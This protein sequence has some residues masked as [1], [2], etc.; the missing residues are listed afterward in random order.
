MLRRKVY[1]CLEN[2]LQWCC[3]LIGTKW[4]RK[5]NGWTLVKAEQEEGRSPFSCPLERL[6]RGGEASP[7]VGRKVV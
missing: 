4:R 6:P 3:A 1:Y 7:G 2:R 5:R